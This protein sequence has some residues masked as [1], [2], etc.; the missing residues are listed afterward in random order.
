M[1]IGFIGAGKAGT[2]LGR[3]LV[4]HHNV[5]VGYA[6]RTEASAQEAASIT[7][8]R[9]FVSALE[10][11]KASDLI[12]IST[13]DSALSLVWDELSLAH[14]QGEIVL[15]SKIVIHLSGCSTSAVFDGAHD[16]GV[17]VC[18]AHPLLA[19]GSK[20]FAHEQLASAH[21]SLEGDQEALDR[22]IPILKNAG[23][24]V[25]IL[26]AEDKALY[27]AAAVFA[28]NL[29]LAPLNTSVHLLGNCGFSEE[30]A[31]KALTPL[32]R[33]N[34]ENFCRQ[35]AA[36]SLTGPVERGDDKTIA[37]HLTVL[38]KQSK[39]LY[40]TLSQALVSIAQEKHPERTYESLKAIEK[41]G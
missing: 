6:S 14:D 29:V 4:Y 1:N 36:F 11:A 2:A 31:R 34:I 40:C 38:D 25:H 27:H 7:H 16:R 3:Y 32:I 30:D 19:F 24:A 33:E 17:S 28:S 5:V 35:G 21:F 39:E 20:D 12:V 23:N 41:G 9:Y 8:T 15:T 10:L 26:R 22:V 13:P 37:A 18:S